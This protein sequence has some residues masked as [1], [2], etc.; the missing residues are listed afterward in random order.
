MALYLRDFRITL[1]YLFILPLY[2]LIVPVSLFTQT[3]SNRDRLTKNAA[4]VSLFVLEDIAPSLTMR[5]FYRECIFAKS[6]LP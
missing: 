5:Q 1:Y 2:R 6:I 3:P 4:N